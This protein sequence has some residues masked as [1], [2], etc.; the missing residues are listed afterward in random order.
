MEY[1][2]LVEEQN[3]I[4]EAIW[5]AKRDG[6]VS[7]RE[8]LAVRAAQDEASRHIWRQ[9]HDWQTAYWRNWRLY[10]SRY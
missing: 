4:A 1:R 10:R 2:R 3:A 5:H 6:R 8:Y 7:Y 9:K